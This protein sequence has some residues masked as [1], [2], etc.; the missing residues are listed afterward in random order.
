MYTK[1][2][3][4]PSSLAQVPLVLEKAFRQA[5]YG[6]P[7]A[8]YVDLPADFITGTIAFGSHH[9]HD[10]I[11]LVDSKDNNQLNA[12]LYPPIAEPPRCQADPRAIQAAVR[13]L[14][15]ASRPLII[16]GKGAAYR[17]RTDAERRG[18]A[19]FLTSTGGIPVLA[20]PMGKGLVPDA[21]AL[22]VGSARSHVLREADVVLLLG[23]R[24][25]W[26]LH[27][28]QRPR[29]NPHVTILQVDV[30]AE[31]FGENVRPHAQHISMLGDICLVVDQL[32]A[33][34]SGGGGG[35]GPNAAATAPATASTTASDTTSTALSAWWTSIR[36]KQAK[37]R[38][39]S[40]ELFQ[41]KALPMTYYRAFWEIKQLLPKDVLLVSEGANT[42]VSGPD[43]RS[44]G[45]GLVCVV[46]LLML[47]LVGW[48]VGRWIGHWENRARSVSASLPH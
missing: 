47:M 1:F 30:H 13:L 35:G 6:R 29:W 10:D 17:V 39:A 14:R 37:N 19:R 28:G 26:M 45:W 27:F 2:S 5:S 36:Q 9:D 46:L 40:E 34:F 44:R 24:L 7:G 15:G 41:S 43:R 12:M 48:S 16:L 3:A 20:T 31:E 8:C 33:E 22:V 4:R 23:A 25:N 11:V 38:A 18:L 32:T 21:H 42:M